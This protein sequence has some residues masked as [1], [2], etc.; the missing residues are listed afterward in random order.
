MVRDC[1]WCGRNEWTGAITDT[2]GDTY[3][4][5]HRHEDEV[6]SMIEETDGEF[7]EEA[8]DA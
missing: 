6:R 4:F 8:A 2:Y 7:D 1:W 3:Y 5:C